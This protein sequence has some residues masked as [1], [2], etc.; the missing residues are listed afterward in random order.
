MDGEKDRERTTTT[1]RKEDNE[2]M[3][4]ELKIEMK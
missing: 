1:N 4:G 2:S 3:V